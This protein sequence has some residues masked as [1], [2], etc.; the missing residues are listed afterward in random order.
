MI[1]KPAFEPTSPGP[2]IDLDPVL[3]DIS[4]GGQEQPAR[5]DNARFPAFASVIEPLLVRRFAGFD[6]GLAQHGVAEGP[7]GLV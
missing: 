5:R 4:P 1:D 6:P 3:L 7:D 2:D